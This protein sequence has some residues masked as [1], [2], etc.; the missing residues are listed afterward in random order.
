MPNTKKFSKP[1][2]PPRWWVPQTPGVDSTFLALLLGP[3]QKGPENPVELALHLEGKIDQLVK[4]AGGGRRALKEL[5]VPVDVELE[6][7]G[8]ED[9]WG[10]VLLERGPAQEAMNLVD[11]K[12]ENRPENQR[13][14]LGPHP[15][16][17]KEALVEYHLGELL[18]SV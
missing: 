6:L 13:R 14:A 7:E 3:K 11:W 16:D 9:Q 8:R 15:S 1:L 2:V 18:E 5:G 4:E 10:A 17:L 12:L